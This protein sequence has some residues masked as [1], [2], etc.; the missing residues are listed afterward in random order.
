MVASSNII[1]LNDINTT[2]KI[3][4]SEGSGPVQ[5]ADQA[6]SESDRLNRGVTN[7]NQSFALRLDAVFMRGI[8]A[9]F[10]PF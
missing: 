5:C 6:L 1:N 3:G 4:F 10:W 7:A 2:C 8:R 9:K